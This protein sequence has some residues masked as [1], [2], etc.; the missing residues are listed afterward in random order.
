MIMGYIA[1]VT[2]YQYIQYANRT[3]EAEKKPM[4]VIQGTKAVM[5]IRN[6]NEHLGEEIASK[7]KDTTVSNNLTHNMLPL[8]RTDIIFKQGV[9]S[10]IVAQTTAELT[11]LGRLVNQTI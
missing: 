7:S 5:P 3:A 8:I 9:P 4:N 10:D 1:P 11:G 6:F 2:P